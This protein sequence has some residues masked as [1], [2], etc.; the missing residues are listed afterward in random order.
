MP[1]ARPL[2]EVG[3]TSQFNMGGNVSFSVLNTFD[4]RYGS[5]EEYET[6]GPFRTAP[7][8]FLS[9]RLFSAET[10]YD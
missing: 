5:L 8:E 4:Y 7:F 10:S 3:A 2:N 9:L 1:F 6:A